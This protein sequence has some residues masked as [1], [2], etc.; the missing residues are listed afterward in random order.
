MHELNYTFPSIQV[1]E[2]EILYVNYSIGLKPVLNYAY[3]IQI[4]TLLKVKQSK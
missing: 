2:T 1:F 4:N 3:G